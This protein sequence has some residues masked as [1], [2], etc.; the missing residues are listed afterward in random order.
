[1]TWRSVVRRAASRVS[2]RSPGST[3]KPRASSGD[4]SG[5]LLEGTQSFD[6]RDWGLKPPKLGLVK[7]HPDIEVRVRLLARP[8]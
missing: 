2:C 8:A 1:M 4:A 5:V 6:V 7:V 3:P